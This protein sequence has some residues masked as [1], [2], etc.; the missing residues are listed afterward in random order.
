MLAR[1]AVL[2][3]I[4]VV[5]DSSLIACACAACGDSCE[6]T[7]ESHPWLVP[8]IKIKCAEELKELHVQYKLRRRCECR[9][10][11]NLTSQPARDATKAIWLDGIRDAH[12]GEHY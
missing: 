9:C 11:C 4:R 2:D 12:P 1:G 8:S 6:D 7:V 3:P 10:R 5:C